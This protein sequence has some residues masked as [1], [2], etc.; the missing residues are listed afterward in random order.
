MSDIMKHELSLLPLSLAEAGGEMHCT[1]TTK[2]ELVNI[3]MN[4]I[5]LPTEV[6]KD[7]IM[8]CVM[9]DG[10]VL[11]QSL[12]KPLRCKTF[13]DYANVFM[14]N[15]THFVGEHTTRVDVVFNR[16]TGDESI[17]ADLHSKRVE[18][19]KPISTLVD[20][21]DVP[22]PQVWSN[23]ISLDENKADDQIS[24]TFNHVY[25]QGITRAV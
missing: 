2:S 3:L 22:L 14:K 6:N 1:T 21:S 7:E 5:E 10:H 25:G 17:K 13:E 23:F 8:T 18:K 20:G 4:G 11:I 9:I 24:I 16:Y 12:G 19:K 15:V